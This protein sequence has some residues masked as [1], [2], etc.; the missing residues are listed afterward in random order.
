MFSGHPWV[1]FIGCIGMIGAF[2]LTN[3]L[4]FEDDPLTQEQISVALVLCWGF[5]AV[6]YAS[7]V[8]GFIAV[9]ALLEGMGFSAGLEPM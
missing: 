6:F 8:L 3:R 2:Y 5:A 1:A 9:L 7:P 4:H